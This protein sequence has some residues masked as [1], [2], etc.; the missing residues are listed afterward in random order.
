MI[1]SFPGAQNPRRTRV[2]SRAKLRCSGHVPL[3]ADRHVAVTQGAAPSNGWYLAALR[4][5]DGKADDTCSSQWGT[6]PTFG[7]K[8]M[9]IM[10]D[11]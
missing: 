6:D 3:F 11:T 10:Q 5:R 8:T 1:R 7:R 9:E 2:L 4:R